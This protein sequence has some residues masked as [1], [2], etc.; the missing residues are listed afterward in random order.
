MDAIPTHNVQNLSHAQLTDALR[1]TGGNNH[2]QHYLQTV[3]SLLQSN[4]LAGPEHASAE[5]I[6]PS[7]GGGIDSDPRLME[8]MNDE[9]ESAF[10]KAK[11]IQIADAVNDPRFGESAPGMLYTAEQQN[12]AEA[13]E[14]QFSKISEYTGLGTSYSEPTNLHI[15]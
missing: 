9:Y 5:H 6:I 3:G 1:A 10:Q 14:T 12:Y 15:G 8:R 7:N 11:R 13:L 4:S 2:H